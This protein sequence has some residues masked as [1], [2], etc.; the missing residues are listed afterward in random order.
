MEAEIYEFMQHSPKPRVFPTKQEL[1]AAG[2]TDL[3]EYVTALGGWLAFGWDI[4]DNEVDERLQSAGKVELEDGKVRP[5]RVPVT[6]L[7]TK[8]EAAEDGGVHQERASNDSLMI[9]HIGSDGYEDCS[10]APS[11]SVRSL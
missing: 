1:I 6:V 2:R 8:D 9:N 5:E 4:N 7:S 11:S 10:S 3:V